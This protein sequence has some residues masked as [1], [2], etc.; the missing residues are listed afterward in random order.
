MRKASLNEWTFTRHALSRAVDMALDAD[1]LR[2]ALAA[3]VRPLPSPERYPGRHMIHTE[4]IIL[5]VDLE[6]RIV[7]TVIW[8][9]W[10]GRTWRALGRN[11]TPD[12][13]EM[14]RDQGT[15][16]KRAPNQGG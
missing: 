15:Q 10:D 8:N 16:H 7:H 13:I 3:D 2:A 5:C 12:E 14:C 11:G 1:E 6:R 9:T 4:R